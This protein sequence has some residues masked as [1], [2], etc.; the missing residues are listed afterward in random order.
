MGNHRTVDSSGEV[1]MREAPDAIFYV[2]KTGCQWAM[3]PHDFP[4]KSM[5]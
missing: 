4:S 5:L 3:L 2:L 1:D